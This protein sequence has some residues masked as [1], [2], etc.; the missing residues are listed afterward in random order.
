VAGPAPSRGRGRCKCCHHLTLAETGLTCQQR[1]LPDRNAL[2]PQPSDRLR[3]DVGSAANDE[4][5]TSGLLSTVL[6]MSSRERRRRDR[7]A[8]LKRFGQHMLQ[9]IWS[10]HVR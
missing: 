9:I 2:R 8:A 5:S 7:R 4:M 6:G 1:Q 10:Q 3:R